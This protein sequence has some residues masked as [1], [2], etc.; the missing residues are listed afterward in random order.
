MGLKFFDYAV[1]FVLLVLTFLP[2]PSD[3]F[4]FGL[5]LIEPLAALGY[6]FIR[7]KNRNRNKSLKRVGAKNDV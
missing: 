2:D 1:L 4:D 5:P 6:F 7:S 3:L